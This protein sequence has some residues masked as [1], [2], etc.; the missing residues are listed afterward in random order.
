MCNLFPTSRPGRGSIVAHRVVC[1]SRWLR[2]CFA[3]S[4]RRR[5][6]RSRRRSTGVVDQTLARSFAR[7]GFRAARS[8]ALVGAES[9]LSQDASI[10]ITGG[11][12]AD[13]LTNEVLRSIDGGISWSASERAPG[14]QARRGHASVV[15]QVRI[16]VVQDSWTL[17]S[18]PHRT[19]LCGSLEVPQALSAQTKLGP[20]LIVGKRGHR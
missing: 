1:R 12:V 7:C 9:A 13:V 14:W 19:G 11:L 18:P 8:T 16:P 17:A 2:F 3:A 20:A 15:L 4:A 10:L 6:R 5:G